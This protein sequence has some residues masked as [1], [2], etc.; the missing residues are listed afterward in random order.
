MDK[1]VLS[2][3][4]VLAVFLIAFLW[5]YMTKLP[6]GDITNAAI[7]VVLGSVVGVPSAG[8]LLKKFG[9]I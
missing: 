8:Y 4:T 6:S 9:I 3:G 7:I 5:M 1:K 2:L